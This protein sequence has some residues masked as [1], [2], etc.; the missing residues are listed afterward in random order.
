VT[1]IEALNNNTINSGSRSRSQLSRRTNN[2]RFRHCMH[3]VAIGVFVTFGLMLSLLSV[4]D[5]KFLYVEIGFIPDNSIYDKK[6]VAVGLWSME[7]PSV[8]GKCYT[9]DLSRQ[10]GSITNKDHFFKYIFFNG[11]A[12]WGAA[13][14]MAILGTVFGF[15]NVVCFLLLFYSFVH[16]PFTS[17]FTS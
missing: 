9:L 5:C 7:D 12:I 6:S 2:S 13:R 1:E 16:F 17:Q 8:P 14:V 3:K 4:V 11:D 15:I 10:V